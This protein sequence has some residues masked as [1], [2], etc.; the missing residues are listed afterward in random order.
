M[1][2]APDSLKSTGDVEISP[3]MIEA[4]LA[5]WSEYDER[6]ESSDEMIERVYRA[7]SIKA[8]ESVCVAEGR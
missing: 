3:E 4:G 8:K 6:F 1:T 5:A 7:M 2:K